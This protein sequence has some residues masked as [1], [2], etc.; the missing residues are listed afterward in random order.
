MSYKAGNWITGDEPQT[1]T[2][3]GKNV[4]FDCAMNERLSESKRNLIEPSVKQC[5]VARRRKTLAS[6]SPS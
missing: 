2:V 4:R 5:L 1:K 6:L 3:V